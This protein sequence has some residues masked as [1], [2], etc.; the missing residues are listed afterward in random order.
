MSCDEGRPCKRCIARGCAD[1]CRGMAVKFSFVIA[2]N[3][4]DLDGKRKRRGRKRKNEFGE[5]GNESSDDIEVDEVAGQNPLRE[6]SETTESEDI[7]HDFEEPAFSIPIAGPVRNLN[8]DYNLYTVGDDDSDKI[9][10]AIYGSLEDHSFNM[11]LYPDVFSKSPYSSPANS[12]LSKLYATGTLFDDI[13]Q[14]G[15]GHNPLDLSKTKN[16]YANDPF[17]VDFDLLM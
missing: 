1:Q 6:S 14:D 17:M 3:N 4:F 13:T 9:R 7:S 5:D 10:S 11:N 8:G 12:N 16:F 15:S 2:H